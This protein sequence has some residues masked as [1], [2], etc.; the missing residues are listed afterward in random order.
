MYRI[1]GYL[2]V[3]LFI[4]VTS[5]YWLRRLNQWVLH[6]RNADMQRLIKP[7]RSLHK[8]LAA[9]LA[10]IAAIHGYLALGSLR[11][12]TGSIVWIAVLVT[13]G[14]GFSFYKK[15]KPNL[16]KWHKGMA[17]TVALLIALHLIAPNILYYL[18]R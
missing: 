6:V 17:L 7:L 10:V 13:A 15:K 14:L 12:H 1:L 16:F 9:C 2:N 4:V 5:P 11:L 3:V 18:F 8:P